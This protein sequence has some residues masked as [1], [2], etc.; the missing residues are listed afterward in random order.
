M[1]MNI[2]THRKFM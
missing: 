2:P 1:S